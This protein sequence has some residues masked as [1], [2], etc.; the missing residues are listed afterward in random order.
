MTFS[1]EAIQDIAELAVY[2][3]AGSYEAAT[4]MAD[5]VFAV[6]N[7]IARSPYLGHRRPELSDRD[8]R[9]RAVIPGSKYLVVY[10]AESRPVRILRVL[11]GARNLIS[12]GL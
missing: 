3:E 7:E 8:V 11:H 12:I 6:C 10:N 1:P 5:R 2:L 9:V 4:R